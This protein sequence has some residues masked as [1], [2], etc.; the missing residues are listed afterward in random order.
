MIGNAKFIL[1]ESYK[2]NTCIC[3]VRFVPFTLT[4]KEFVYNIYVGNCQ[5]CHCVIWNLSSFT[6]LGT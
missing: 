3:F 5:F 2:T 4:T 1:N 6:K